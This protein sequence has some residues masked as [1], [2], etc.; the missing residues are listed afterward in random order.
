MAFI[1]KHDVKITI[2]NTENIGRLIDQILA[3]GVYKINSLEWKPFVEIDAEE[4]AIDEGKQQGKDLC[5][6]LN[7]KMGDVKIIEEKFESDNDDEGDEG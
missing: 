6:H 4:K 7:K 5:G 1:V 3:L 2:I